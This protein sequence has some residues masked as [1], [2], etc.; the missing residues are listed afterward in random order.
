[1]N[2]IIRFATFSAYGLNKERN[3]L[4]GI[5]PLVEVED[6]EEMIE[7]AVELLLLS[8]CEESAIF[9]HS[10][11]GQTI[12]VIRQGEDCIMTY[13]EKEKNKYS[14]FSEIDGEYRLC[15][16]GLMIETNNNQ[17]KIIGG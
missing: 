2:N 10:L 16:Y 9:L 3:L 17:W 6:I 12:A 15:C 7:T 11:D 8:E 13:P 4:T 14:F 5:D 1:M